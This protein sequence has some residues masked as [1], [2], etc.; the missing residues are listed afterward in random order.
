MTII[1]F[2]FLLIMVLK[3]YEDGRPDDLTVIANTDSTDTLQE[4]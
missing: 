3:V 2:S 4:F 1:A